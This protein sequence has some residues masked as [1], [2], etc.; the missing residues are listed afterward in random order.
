MGG[1]IYNYNYNNDVHSDFAQSGIMKK[2]DNNKDKKSKEGVYLQSKV[3]RG[4]VRE[5]TLK[6][7]LLIMKKLK[8]DSIYMKRLKLVSYRKIVRGVFLEP[9]RCL[10]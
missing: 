4:S 3:S 9:S 7:Y 6:F 5:K 1:F 2:H 8:V 10:L